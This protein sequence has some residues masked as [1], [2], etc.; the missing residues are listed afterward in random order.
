V[1][2][3]SGKFLE[4]LRGSHL[5]AFRATVCTTFQTGTTP[6]GTVVE[7]IGGEVTSS[8]TA[9]V[10]SSLQLVTSAAWPHA[11][12]DVIT[13]YGNEIYIE[14][15]V[16]YGNSLREFVGLGYF[17]IDTPEQDDVPDGEIT[18]A[19]Q[20]RMAGIVDAR[21][22]A[23]RQFSASLTR[24]ALVS[25]LVA[26]VY[27][28]AVIEWDDT[29]LRDGT[30]GRS[31]IAE[32]DRAQCLQEFMTAISKVGYFDHRGVFVVRTPPAVDG[33]P[34]WTIDAGSK[35]VLVRMSRALTRE[36]VYNAVV[37]TGEAGD[38]APPAR[39]VAY[40][41]DPSSPTYYRGRFGPVPR[42][43]SSPFLTTNAQ[44]Q[45]AAKSLLRQQLGLPYQVEL[46]SVPNPALEPYD[47]VVVAYPLKARSRSTRK[48]THVLDEIKIPLSVGGTVKLKTREQ[49][50]ELIGTD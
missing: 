20:D 46:D 32:E 18:I 17:R 15:G 30:V 43:F 11:A 4:T 47:P 2:A 45:S 7:V 13:P 29:A 34:V 5:A 50:V 25:T 8:S 28:S 10:R 19:G 6:T 39:G 24:G 41:L 38:T 3:V 48:E 44:A 37:A 22:L 14:R 36:R 1:R 16:A 23:P 31:V 9:M 21:F 12:D 26:E 40:N 42:F 49:Q 33:P 35:G 27:P